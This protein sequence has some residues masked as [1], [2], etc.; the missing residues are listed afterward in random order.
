MLK[1]LASIL[2][3]S[4][5]VS[6]AFAAEALDCAG[7]KLEAASALAKACA[8]EEALSVDEVA[9]LEEMSTDLAATCPDLTA[10]EALDKGLLYKKLE[11]AENCKN[12]ADQLATR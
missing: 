4:F 11:L 2:I 6:S 12:K 9:D 3:S 5:F 8:S 1:V 7:L 10:S